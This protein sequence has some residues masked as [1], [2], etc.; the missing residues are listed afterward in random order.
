MK[1]YGI[2]FYEQDLLKLKISYL[3]FHGREGGWALS[4][5]QKPGVTLAANSTSELQKC[6]F[7]KILIYLFLPF[8][9]MGGWVSG[10][11]KL[12]RGK[13]F[14][15]QFNFDALFTKFLTRRIS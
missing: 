10:S 9:F 4:Q 1:T 2:S 15:D 5:G 3:I 14:L 12:A 6:A 8:Y 11:A 13:N 7:H